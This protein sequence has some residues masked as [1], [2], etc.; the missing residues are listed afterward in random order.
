MTIA[1]PPA[2]AATTIASAICTRMSC[3]RVAPIARRTARSRWRPSARTMKRFATLAQAMSRTIADA[4]KSTQSGRDDAA[5]QCFV[6][7]THDRAMLG[8]HA[9]VVRRSAESLGEPTG[10]RR[11]LVRD[12]LR[13]GARRHTSHERQAELPGRRAPR[14]GRRSRSTPACL[15]DGNLNSGSIDADDGAMF[16]AMKIRRPRTLGRRRT[17]T[18]TAR[19]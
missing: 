13:R 9:R 1:T 15:R 4:A 6:E 10:Q 8:D 18:A 3:P 2:S 5:E 16:P 7:R 17:T 14:D 12:G 11:E 19:G